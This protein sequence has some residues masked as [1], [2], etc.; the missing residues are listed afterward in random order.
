MFQI[1]QL[2]SRGNDRFGLTMIVASLVAIALIVATLLWHQKETGETQIRIQGVSLARMLSGLPY[3]QLVPP[4]GQHTLLSTIFQSQNDP[5]FAYATIVDT[6]N[7]PVSIASV[8]GLTMPSMDWPDRPVGWP[9]DR[10]L[11]TS[12]GESVMEFYTPLYAD[13]SIAAYLRLGYFL[14]GMSINLKQLPFFATLA[15]IIFLLT[16]LFYLLVR[17]EIR[18][19]REANAKISMVI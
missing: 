14:P 3:A 8:P 19:L 9:S 10:T 12:K 5:N 13:G 1:K 4:R 15:L 18:P 11:T 6:E 17:K 2:A 7:K 16:P